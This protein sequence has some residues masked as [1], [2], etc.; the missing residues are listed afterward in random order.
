MRRDTV[1]F[2]HPCIGAVRA[3][4]SGGI[5]RSSPDVIGTLGTLPPR[6]LPGLGSNSIRG[7]LSILRRMPELGNLW[8]ERGQ[9]V[10]LIDVSPRAVRAP[11]A[12]GPAIGRRFPLVRRIF[13]ALPPRSKR[14]PERYVLRFR[15]GI[16]SRVPL[17]DQLW[18][19]GESVSPALCSHGTRRN[20]ASPEREAATYTHG[21]AGRPVAARTHRQSNGRGQLAREAAP[22][23]AKNSNGDQAQK[24]K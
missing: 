12:F 20:I 10:A 11:N 7:Q 13:P 17:G 22:T 23:T 14:R 8:S 15:A 24:R 5:R 4:L 1:R 6:K 19:V 3:A 16:L 21:I 2:R 9:R 18:V